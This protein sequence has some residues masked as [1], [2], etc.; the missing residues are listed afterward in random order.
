MVN[1]LR[2]QGKIECLFSG[3]KIVDKGKRIR[4]KND[5]VVNPVA[6]PNMLAK[7]EIIGTLIYNRF[8]TRNH[9][10]RTNQLWIK[11]NTS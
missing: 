1:G 4:L 9:S 8:I 10:F 7:L 3:C 6:V 5:K 2:L 11:C